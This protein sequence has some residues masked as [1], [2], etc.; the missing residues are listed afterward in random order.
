MSNGAMDEN[1]IA[2]PH[3]EMTIP[4]S[5]GETLWTGFLSLIVVVF[6]ILAVL[7]LANRVAIIPSVIWLLIVS[8]ILWSGWRDAGG[9][10][11]CFCDWIAI[12]A[13]R[14]FA[15][16]AN[17]DAGQ[18]SVRFGYE[19]FGRRF[20]ERTIP[21]YRI[22]SVEWSPG[23]ATSMAGHDMKDWSVALWYDHGDPEKSKKHHMLRK[24][25]QDVYIVG[26]SRPKEDT[27]ALGEDFLSFLRA[28]GSTLLRGDTDSVYIREL[29]TTIQQ[30][31]GGTAL[32]RATHP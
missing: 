5:R 20:Y 21:L 30:A 32:P 31:C 17:D 15:M 12:F 22:E 25:D 2:M 19:L 23:Q 18:P 13:G 4:S 9:I 24:P 26:P 27:A 16:S 29:S 8:W 10:R 6:A 7:N 3:P 11:R 28:I 1:E 14:R